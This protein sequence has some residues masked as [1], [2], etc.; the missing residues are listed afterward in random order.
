MFKTYKIESDYYNASQILIL[1]IGTIFLVWRSYLLLTIRVTYVSFNTN[2]SLCSGK[3]PYKIPAH[4][5]IFYHC[6]YWGCFLVNFH[7]T[8]PWCLLFTEIHISVM[9]LNVSISIYIFSI[10]VTQAACIVCLVV[11]Q[12]GYHHFTKNV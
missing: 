10:A 5:V 3:N 4:L 8:S 9:R 2:L 12:I 6:L 7:L 11:I 1:S